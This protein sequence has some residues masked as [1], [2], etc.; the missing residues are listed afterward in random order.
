MNIYYVYA[1]L[2]KDGTPYY[3]GKGTKRRAWNAHAT[4]PVPNDLSK[5]TIMESNLTELGAWAI[6]RR[7]IRW[8]GRKD[9]GTGILHNKTEGGEGPS[10]ID[11]IGVR[12]PMHK[13]K[14][15]AYQKQRMSETFKGVRKSTLAKLKMSRAKKDVYLGKNNPNYDSKVYT[16]MNAAGDIVNMTSYDFRKAF[17]VDQ[18]NLS[19]LILGKSK[20]IKGWSI[21]NN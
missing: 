1:Y 19:K 4:V 3:I 21:K 7:L 5:I 6:E 12:N 14:Q 11:R 17:N 16:F 20:S 9:L 18:G 2:R 10:S 13:K 15:T 8:Y